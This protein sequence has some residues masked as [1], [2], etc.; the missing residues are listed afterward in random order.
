MNYETIK[1][2]A[3]QSGLTVKDLIALAPQNDPFYV[4]TEG[5]LGKARWFAN[6]WQR[7]G[8][9]TGVH[10]RR[11]H[12]QLVSQDPPVMKPNGKPYENTE[13]DWD[14]LGMASKSARYLGLVDPGAFVDRRNPDP[15][16]NAQYWGDSTPGYYVE[17]RWGGL[18]VQLPRFPELPHLATEGY[19]VGN[20]QPYHLEIWVEKT[21]MNDV[22]EH[23]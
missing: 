2:L 7:F 22:L 9:G 19:D 13:A 16:I 3:R 14:F 5:D 18:D 11:V 23:V 6:L 12:Y 8:Y 4:G 10:L 17:G 15:V 20:L 21:T 1:E